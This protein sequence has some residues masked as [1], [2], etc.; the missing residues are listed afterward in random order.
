MSPIYECPRCGRQVELPTG[1][2]YCKVCGPSS[3]MVRVKMTDENVTV[4]FG[5]VLYYER[6]PSYRTVEKFFEE[7]TSPE[8]YSLF[9][10]FVESHGIYQFWNREYIECL[11]REIKRRIGSDM[12]LEVAAGDG[13]LSFWLRKYGVNIKATDSGKMYDKIKR[14]AEVEIIDAV[15]AIRK[16]KPRMVVASWLPWDEPI[17]IQIFDEKVPYIV[18]IGEEYGACGSERFWSE[19]YWEKAGYKVEYSKCSRWS[20]CRTDYIRMDSAS[21]HSSTAFYTLTR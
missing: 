1:T 17:D 5:D 12:A 4:S 6:L 20:L 21:F 16:Y 11:A 10:D 9:W 8:K 2:Y 19:N 7:Y 14:R 13:M 18:L 3:L 15:S